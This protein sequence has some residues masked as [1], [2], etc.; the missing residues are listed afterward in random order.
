[1]MVNIS[2]LNYSRVDNPVA[3]VVKTSKEKGSG[4]ANRNSLLNKILVEGGSNLF[5]YI[6]NQG[7]PGE[8]EIMVLSSNH[9]YYYDENDLKNIRT[10]VN[11]KKLN[12]VEHLD[13]FLDT[14][15]R[16]LP[17][18]ANFIGCFTDSKI[19]KRNN[20]FT[21]YHSTRIL[22][23]LINALDSKTNHYMNRNQVLN[24]F[25]AN[26]FRVVD[27]TEKDGLTFFHAMSIRKKAELRA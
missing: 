15:Y 2:A 3:D 13:M 27:M 18:D 1:M 17:P 12:M 25:A 24:L 7:I 6:K 8:D 5:E 20:G 11:L 22:N 9:H 16:I 26:G 14:L 19:L 4:K 21:L 23:Q 10:L